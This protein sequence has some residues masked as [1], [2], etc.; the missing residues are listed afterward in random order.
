MI[1]VAT[2]II[3][4]AVMNGF[5]E[6][7]IDKILGLN[8]HLIIQPMDTKLTDY[9][10]VAARIAKVPGVAAAI[11]LVE[12][13][14]AGE[15]PVDLERRPRPRHPR[16]GPAQGAR[17]RQEREARFARAISTRPTAWRSARAWPSPS[18]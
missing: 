13:P 8:G 15:R 2:L 1:G 5:R 6:Q 10:D 17:R 12:G 7:L 18:A 3:V 16:R 14:G 4:M 9:A 11:P